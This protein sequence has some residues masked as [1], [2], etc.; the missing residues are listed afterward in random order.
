MTLR[1][2]TSC[3]R[4]PAGTGV[5]YEHEYV[6]DRA[7]TLALVPL[8]FADGVPRRLGNR[9]EVVVGGVRCRSPAGWRWTSSWPISAT[10]RADRRRRGAVRP[11]HAREP[12]AAEW[13]D[14]VGTNGMKF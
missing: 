5:S 1:S 12:T 10:R 7:T 6:T 2:R 4:V 11:R 13:A 3:K 14:W 8:G 9:G